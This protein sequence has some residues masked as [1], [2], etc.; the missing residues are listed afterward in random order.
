MRSGVV[1]KSVLDLHKERGAEQAA[2]DSFLCIHGAEITDSMQYY[3]R[4]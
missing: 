3:S 1:H 4:T 2:G